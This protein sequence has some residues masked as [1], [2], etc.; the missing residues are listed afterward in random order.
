MTTNIMTWEQ[1]DTLLCHWGNEY[2]VV[3]RGSWISLPNTPANHPEMVSRIAQILAVPNLAG[4]E[5][6]F[7]LKALNDTLSPSAAPAVHVLAAAEPEH[8]PLAEPVPHKATSGIKST[9][10]YELPTEAEYVAAG[11]PQEQYAA[12]MAQETG[13]EPPKS[14]GVTGKPAL[15][16]LGDEGVT[17]ATEATPPDGAQGVGSSTAN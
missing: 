6:G 15:V 16:Q 10:G 5:Q 1:A 8:V 4:T 9:H 13:A 3:R 7:R 2:G 11:Y 17:L 14:N 12:F